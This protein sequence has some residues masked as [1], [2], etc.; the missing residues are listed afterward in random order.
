MHLAC[1]TVSLLAAAA[2]QLSGAVKLQI[3]DGR[4]VVDGVFVNGHGPYRFLLDT[5]TTLNHIEAGLARSIGLTAS[6]RT[7]LT[8]SVGRTIVTGGEGIEVRLEDAVAGDQK[9]LFAGL[10][11]VHQLASGIHGIL[12]QEFLARFDYRLDLRGKQL[13][14]G[15]QE[16]HGHRAPFRLTSGRPTV[17]TSLGDLVLDSG[18]ASVILFGVRAEGSAGGFIRTLAGSQMVGMVY[19]RL[20]IEGRRVWSGDAVALDGQTEPGVAGLMPLSLFRSVYFCNS[21]GYAVFE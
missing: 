10:N 16:R 7:E 12:G 18:A 17:T 5:A 11:V 14:F 8:S 9:F 3:V 2:N 21:S 4:P 13:E 20:A 15:S 19:R 1:L 6:F